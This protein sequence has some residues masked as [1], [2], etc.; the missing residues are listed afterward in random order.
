MIFHYEYFI[1]GAESV[2]ISRDESSNSVSNATK[3]LKDSS[4]KRRHANNEIE[5]LSNYETGETRDLSLTDLQRLILLKQ[6]LVLTKKLKLLE[7][8]V[9]QENEISFEN[10]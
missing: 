10:F 2:A 5:V 8:K 9:T 6:N 4:R 1:T 7:N 3:I